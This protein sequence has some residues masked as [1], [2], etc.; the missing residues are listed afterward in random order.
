MPRRLLLVDDEAVIRITLSAILSKHGFEVSA[1][2]TV[3]EALQ[4]ITSQQ[5]EVLLSDLNIGNPGDG[6][7]VVSA[8][9]R[10]QPDAVTMILTG[11]P[12]FETALEAIRQ[13]VD[14][15][16]LKPADVPALILT[17]E[18]KLA[19]PPRQRHLPP[20]KRVAM[21]LQEHLQRIE[22]MWLSAVE[23]DEALTRVAF[24]KEQRLDHL[25][26]MLEQV[27]RE[28]QSY[29]G[30]ETAAHKK[31]TGGYDI[32][33]NLEGYTPNM[34]LA[35]FCMLRR[36]VARIVQENLLAVNLS[37]LV[38]D[39]AQVNESL[40]EQAQAALVTLSE[41]TGASS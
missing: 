1:A 7:T 9:R 22:D 6:L 41:F 18:N 31:I 32:R 27:I 33:R 16:V 30:E 39:L 2:A 12:A 40:D 8:M 10:T 11:Y 19:T 29:S 14:D 34:M 24:S 21:I 38:P 25:R 36:V 23:K 17:I 35:E 3:A 5:F 20:P 37:Y 26:G 28:A 4:K 15:Y 13:Q